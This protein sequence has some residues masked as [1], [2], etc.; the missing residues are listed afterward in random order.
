MDQAK[1]ILA[2]QSPRRAQLLREDGY[3]FEQ[4]MPPFTDPPQ[5]CDPGDTSPDRLAVQLSIKKALSVFIQLGSLENET[6][7]VLAADTICLGVD[8]QLIGTPQSRHQAR[9]IIRGFV[10][11]THQVISAV[12]IIVGYGGDPVTLC[13]RATVAFGPLEEN[14]LEAYLHSDQWRG[15]AGGY[16]LFDRLAQGWPI[17]VTGDPT[18]VVGLPMR[19]LAPLLGRL[20]IINVD[21]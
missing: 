7:V 9:G 12:A 6:A 1:L 5:P 8:Q 20:G 16:N 14:R 3:V 19:R 13:D 4:V 15:K 18:T 10:G 11:Q 2:S 21:A 17:T